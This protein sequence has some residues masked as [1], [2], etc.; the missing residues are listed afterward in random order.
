M[1]AK[2]YRVL[3]ADDEYWICENLR[4]IIP[5]KD[6]GLEFLEPASD[7]EE[8]MERLQEERVDILIT[9]INMQIGRAHV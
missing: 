9:D 6:Y 3:A 7:G 8:V 2:T 4:R 1:V 5:W